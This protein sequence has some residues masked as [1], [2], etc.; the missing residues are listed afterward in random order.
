VAVVVVTGGT[1]TLGHH[2]VP[3]LRD[4]GA[5]R[6]GVN[7]VPDRADGRVTWEQWLANG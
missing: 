4:G 6:R 2:L 3:R 7:P 1:G 5:F